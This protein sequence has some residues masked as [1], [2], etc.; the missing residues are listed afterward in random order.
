MT[1][2]SV[3]RFW[4]WFDEARGDLSIR[5]VEERARCPRG[6]IGNPYSA[7]R[8]PTTLVCQSIAKGLNIEEEEVLRKASIL[9]PRPK[10]TTNLK[11]ANYLFSQLSEQEQEFILVQMRALVLR[12][13]GEYNSNTG[14]G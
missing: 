13:N 11:E 12:K 14:Q 6:R 5:Q 3:E 1:L 8:G 7:K 10:E 2:E 4:N 9:A